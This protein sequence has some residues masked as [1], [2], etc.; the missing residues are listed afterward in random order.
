MAYVILFG[1]GDAGG[2]ILTEHGIK[3]IPPWTGVG[4]GQLRA[5]NALVATRAAAGPRRAGKGLDGLIDTL[6]RAVMEAANEDFGSLGN[7]GILYAADE[8][9]VYCGTGGPVHVPIRPP[10]PQASARFRAAG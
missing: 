3:P 9:G 5:L 6:S 4:L 8:D 10:A 2:V 7:G 1:G